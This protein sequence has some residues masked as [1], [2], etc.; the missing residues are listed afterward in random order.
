MCGILS[1]SVVIPSTNPRYYSTIPVVSSP[2][3]PAQI[4][5][6]TAASLLHTSL[7][8]STQCSHSIFFRLI[9]PQAGHRLSAT[10]SC[11]AFPAN[12]RIR[13]FE[14]LV[15]FFGTA[16]RIDSNSPGASEGMVRR[17][18]VGITNETERKARMGAK[19]PTRKD[20]RALTDIAIVSWEC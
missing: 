14:W 8:A 7:M 5:E 1:Q 13:R 17:I 3:L 20:D 12:C 9:P 15:F 18:V 16:R 4:Y 2:A 10:T 6:I 11:K 19:R